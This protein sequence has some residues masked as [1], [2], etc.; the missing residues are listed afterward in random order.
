V[1]VRVEPAGCH[2][3]APQIDALGRSGIARDVGRAP[4]R[5]DAAIAHEQRLSRDTG[6]DVDPAAMEQGGRH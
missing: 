2:K 3:P 6:S 1:H 4:H 5:G